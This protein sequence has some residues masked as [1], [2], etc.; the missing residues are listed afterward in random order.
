MTIHSTGDL[1]PAMLQGMLKRPIA[2]LCLVGLIT[3]LFAWHI[4]KV[5]FRT[6]VYDMIV[7][8]LPEAAD[9]RMFKAD[10]GSD[11]IIRVVIRGAPVFTPEIFDAICRL[12]AKAEQIAGVR[13]IIGLPEIREKVALSGDKSLADF[14]QMVKPVRLFNRNLISEDRKA[15]LLTL[16]LSDDADKESVIQAVERLINDLPAPIQSYQIGMPLVSRFM[17]QFTQKDFLRLPPITFLLMAVVLLILYKS[18]I[19]LM[20]PVA[21]VATALS[22]TLGLMGWVGA[23]LSMMTMIVPV[24]LIAVGTA[25]CLHIISTF[26]MCAAQT[27]ATAAVQE[28][29]RRMTLPT[30]L[31]VSTTIAGLLSLLLNRIQAIHEFALFSCFGLLSLLVILLTGLPAALV[32][33]APRTIR[34]AP[35]PG[36]RRVTELLNRIVR[37]NLKHRKAALA[38][39]TAISLTALAG[40]GFLRVETNPVAFFRAGSPVHHHFHDI[41]QDLSGSFPVHVVVDGGRYDYFE[42]PEHLFEIERLQADLASLPG[43]DKSVSVVDYMKL[44]NYAMNRYD[45]AYYRLPTEPFEIRMVFN[46]YKTILGE[47]LLFRF[48]TPDLSRINILLF[49]HLASSRDFLAIKEHIM[50]HTA[51]QFPESV[52]F[53]VTGFG[54]VAAASSHLLTFGQIK[55]FMLTMIFIFVIMLVLFLSVKVG[56]IALLPNGFPILVNFG[57]MGWFGIELSMITSLIASIAIGL[58]VDDTIHY[59]YCY[60][61]EFKK[62]LNK[63]RAMQDTIL[64]VG[65]PVLFTSIT[66][67]VGFSILLFSHFTPT[68]VFGLLIVVT[69]LAALIGDLVI[70]PSLMLHVELVTAWD[71]LKLMPTMSR[72]TP[73]TAHELNQP[74]NAIKM[75]SEYLKMVSQQKAPVPTSLLAELAMEMGDQVDR[76]ALQINRLMNFSLSSGFQMEST[77]V[78]T[79]VKD[80]AAMF[81]HPLELENIRLKLELDERCPRVYARS[82]RISEVVLNLVTNASEAIAAKRSQPAQSPTEDRILIRT[83]CDQDSVVIE[84]HDSGAG[85]PSHLVERVAEPF[86]TTKK[87]GAGKGLGLC[88][89]NEIVKGFGGRLAIDSKPGKGSSLRVVLPALKT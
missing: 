50:A 22:W 66:I 41:Y 84:I 51:A 45:P 46:Q 36:G 42:N 71:L 88:V 43:V 12:S 4:P 89:S 17:V 58:A 77:D 63:D 23:S 55:S 39:I 48:A 67:G 59:L 30:V 56:L 26:R 34:Q 85:I 57:I 47:D 69:M 79:A 44:V 29:Y 62:D 5:R 68:A 38:W 11:D 60:N 49:T 32:L 28:T 7:E 2:A 65:R 54:V 16:L 18:W 80:A 20:L 72:I 33:F 87:Q 86:F 25:Y 9:Y 70:L 64:H 1:Y 6:S 3:L 35:L 53:D 78:N 61:R 15:T 27:D 24:F 81:A 74:L 31:T 13:R 19:G 82:A 8:S 40:I 21:T 37:L 10:F 83:T 75:G 52:Q 76:A 73:D 14:E